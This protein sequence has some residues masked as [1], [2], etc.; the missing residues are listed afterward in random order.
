LP[1]TPEQDGKPKIPVVLMLSASA[2]AA[3]TGLI[4]LQVLY[5]ILLASPLGGG[6]VPS[7]GEFCF[8]P[9][10][11]LFAFV[12][13]RS[14][15]GRSPDATQAATVLYFL[16]AAFFAIGTV[17]IATH[18][19]ARGGIRVRG[20]LLVLAIFGG[21]CCWCTL[22]AVASMRWRQELKLYVGGA[23]PEPLPDARPLRD[24]SPEDE[25]P[26]R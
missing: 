7:L 20:F 23:R 17:S 3:V 10:L 2:V 18:G 24:E 1:D 22:C 26:P 5:Y 9:V 4:V 15:F 16:G 14:A 12:L 19:F 25:E 21:G 13:W 6:G 11:V 8:L